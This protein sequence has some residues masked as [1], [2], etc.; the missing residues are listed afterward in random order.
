M[1][2]KPELHIESMTSAV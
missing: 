1:W 2:P